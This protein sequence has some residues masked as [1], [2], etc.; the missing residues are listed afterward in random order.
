MQRTTRT[1]VLALLAVG[2]KRGEPSN[3]TSAPAPQ[4][5]QPP[6]MTAPPINAHD[7]NTGDVGGPAR[8]DAGAANPWAERATSHRGSSGATFTQDCPAGGTLGAVWG[9]DVYSDDSSICSAA[10]HA[11]RIIVGSGGPVL[12]FVQPGRRSYRGSARHGVTSQSR[13]V[14]PGS[15]SFSQMLPSEDGTGTT[16]R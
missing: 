14:S 1:I 11:G 15:F 5:A 4:V 3:P 6:A 13:A 16:T 12:V 2:C 9:T 7:V 8:D 10:V